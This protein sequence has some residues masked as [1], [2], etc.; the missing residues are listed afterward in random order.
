[1]HY[2]Y[3]SSDVSFASDK[4]GLHVC[5]E[6]WG[7]CMLIL[8]HLLY[9]REEVDLTAWSRRVHFLADATLISADVCK[10]KKGVLY[11]MYLPSISPCDAFYI[12][13]A[14]LSLLYQPVL[15]AHSCNA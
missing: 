14:S 5:T 10:N 8:R 6:G 12:S 3:S 9:V 1:M 15:L 7:D 4:I 2:L 11:M 13:C